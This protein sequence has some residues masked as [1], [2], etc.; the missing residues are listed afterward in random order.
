MNDS[1]PAEQF[2]LPISPATGNIL[3]TI[4]LVVLG[5]ALIYVIRR[6]IRPEDREKSWGVLRFLGCFA[7]ASIWFPLF[8]GTLWICGHILYD[9]IT[10]ADTVRAE[11]PDSRAISAYFAALAALIA[12]PLLT[13]RSYNLHRQA[14]TAEQGLITDRIS[15]AVEQLGA[16]KTVKK[17][18]QE[19]TQPNLEVRIGGLY[20][21]ERIAQ[22][23]VEE[24][25]QIMDILCAYVR[26]KLNFRDKSQNAPKQP[27][28]DDVSTV[29]KIISRRSETQKEK[30][31]AWH[32]HDGQR[33]KFDY[34]LCNFANFNIWN[35]N[36][37]NANFEHCDFSNSHLHQCKFEASVF[38]GALFN[39]T[40]FSHTEFREA[41]FPHL[42]SN[43]TPTLEVIEV[44]FL[45][46]DFYGF[47]LKESIIDEKTQF[48]GSLFHDSNITAASL[49]DQQKDTIL[50]FEDYNPK[51]G[52]I[53]DHWGTLEDAKEDLTPQWREW[54]KTNGFPSK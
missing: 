16:E 29:F 25:I 50:S 51:V 22:Q 2:T 17:N 48:D 7:V 19:S 28:P 6:S 34:Q 37:Q 33:Y 12:A 5:S 44:K 24:H 4:L 35:L 36:F 11:G 15:K 10:I 8:F 3:L 47:D 52:Y 54:Q 31:D 18:G 13:W 20:A 41:S 21:L 23:N 53:P 49:S 45:G 27:L 9:A 38:F 32:G 30:E 1:I 26:E 43:G 46:C 14:N 42:S 40:K 39:K